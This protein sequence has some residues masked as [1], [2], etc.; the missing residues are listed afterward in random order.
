MLAFVERRK[1]RRSP[2]AQDA[3]AVGGPAQAVI[4]EEAV[5]EIGGGAFEDDGRT[6]DQ[7]SIYKADTTMGR[8][9]I[10]SLDLKGR[11]RAPKALELSGLATLLPLRTP[12]A[13]W[14]PSGD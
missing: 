7:L 5:F 3:V 9:S 6:G 1:A 11:H 12:P 10:W 4:A 2:G 14:K 13:V 8:L